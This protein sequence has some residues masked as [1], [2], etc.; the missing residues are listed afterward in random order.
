[1]SDLCRLIWCTLIG[2]FLTGCAGS[3][4]PRAAASAE[5]PATQI[6]KTSDPQQHRQAAA[7][8]TLPPSPWDVGRSQDHSRQTNFGVDAA[9][10]MNDEDDLGRVVVDIGDD[11]LDN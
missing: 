3:R 10:P 5:R 9:H 7:R 6:P 11:L 2:L 1:M 8:R 4:D